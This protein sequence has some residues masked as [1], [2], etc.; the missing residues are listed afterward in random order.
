MIILCPSWIRGVSVEGTA[1]IIS[2]SSFILVEF[3][4]VREIILAPNFLAFDN[5][6]NTFFER[7]LVDIPI[8]T[9]FFFTMLHTDEKKFF[10]NQNQ[11]ACRF[12]LPQVS[13]TKFAVR[14]SSAIFAHKNNV[15]GA[16]N[17]RL[18][19]RVLN[20]QARLRLP[21]FNVPFAAAVRNEHVVP[22]VNTVN[23]NH[24]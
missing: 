14:G 12:R 1:K 8:T 18:A 10:Q 19:E 21:E 20:L 11:L 9:S 2:L 22:V 16:G 15:T 3:F 17:L 13:N 7:P 23:G 4:P 5:P 6:N 24:N